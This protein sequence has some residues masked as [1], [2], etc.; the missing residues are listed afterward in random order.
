MN[1]ELVDN[2]V[3]ALFFQSGKGEEVWEKSLLVFCF[4]KNL[5]EN[6]LQK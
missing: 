3:L 1:A 5:E 6:I 4:V 2:V